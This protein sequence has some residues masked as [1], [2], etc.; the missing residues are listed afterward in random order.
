[1]K[2]KASTVERT[3]GGHGGSDCFHFDKDFSQFYVDSGAPI[4]Q[5]ES[6][7]SRRGEE[8]GGEEEPGRG[9]IN[10]KFIITLCKLASTRIL[11]RPFGS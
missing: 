2:L 1:M 6:R 5:S 4:N 3:V 8:F 9:V 10:H 7:A 11:S